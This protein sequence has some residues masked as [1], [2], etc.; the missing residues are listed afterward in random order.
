M[1]YYL[2]DNPRAA[3]VLAMLVETAI[4]LAWAFTHGR[5]RAR[6]LVV[7]PLLVAVALGLDRLVETDREQLVRHTREVVQAAE[8]EN[9]EAIVDLL[10]EQFMLANGFDKAKAAD[11]IRRHLAQPIIASN[12]IRDLLVLNVQQDTGV[13]EFKVTTMLDRRSQYAL[14]RLLNSRWRFDFVR[15]ADGVFRLRDINM[16]S[17]NGGEPLDVWAIRM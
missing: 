6:Y 8:D 9:A 10:S 5:V 17:F 15:D 11:V 1:T 14:A 12:I 4:L 3:I 13:V 2:F 16:M 7:G